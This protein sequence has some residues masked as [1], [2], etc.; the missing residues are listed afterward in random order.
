[1][2]FLLDIAPQTE[3]AGAVDN[4]CAVIVRLEGRDSVAYPFVT[5]YRCTAR[6]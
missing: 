6:Q 3:K 4:A 1:M 5:A 2:L